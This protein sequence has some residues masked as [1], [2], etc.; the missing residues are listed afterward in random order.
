MIRHGLL[1]DGLFFVSSY[2]DWYNLKPC[3]VTYLILD[4]TLPKYFG[5]KTSKPTIF[6]LYTVKVY[7]V[8][9][10]STFFLLDIMRKEEEKIPPFDFLDPYK[11]AVFNFAIFFWYSFTS[12]A[13]LILHGLILCYA[14]FSWTIS[15]KAF[16][17][18][19][20]AHVVMIKRYFE[21]N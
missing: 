16:D 21:K 13:Y 14:R 1:K 8:T 10:P 11:I 20:R 19:T 7:A 12:M 9:W 2:G 18:K 5:D 17:V 15:E 6:D 3:K 4:N